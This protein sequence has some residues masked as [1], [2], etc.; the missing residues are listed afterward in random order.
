M[1]CPGCGSLWLIIFIGYDRYNVIVNGIRGSKITKAKAAGMVLFAV[2]YAS[3]TITPAFLG[4][5][6]GV[7][8]GEDKHKEI[9][10]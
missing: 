6:G 3:C 9:I 4:I 1:L 10:L 7:M 5:W 2:T 8:Y